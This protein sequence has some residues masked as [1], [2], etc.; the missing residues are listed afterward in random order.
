MKDLQYVSNRGE[1]P[2]MLDEGFTIC[3]KPRSGSINDMIEI[4]SKKIREG[5]P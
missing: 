3:F 1:V 2:S 4:A 5:F